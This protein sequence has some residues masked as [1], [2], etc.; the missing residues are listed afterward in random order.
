M[1][2]GD[3]KAEVSGAYASAKEIIAARKARKS[4]GKQS[5]GHTD[6]QPSPKLVVEL[7]ERGMVDAPEGDVG[8]HVRAAY[9]RVRTKQSKGAPRKMRLTQNPP[10]RQQW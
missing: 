10:N 5:A 4:S 1:G 7:E 3:V 8:K 6:G 9:G 2:S